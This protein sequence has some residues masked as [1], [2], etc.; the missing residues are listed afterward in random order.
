MITCS[1]GRVTD[2]HIRKSLSELTSV[3]LV[4]PMDGYSDSP[5]FT[6]TVDGMTYEFITMASD[7]LMPSVDDV[8]VHITGVLASQAEWT[9]VKPMSVESAE[10]S[11][12]LKSFGI[13]NGPKNNITFFNL[14]HT[15]GQLSVALANMSPKTAFVDFEKKSVVYYDDMLRESPA[16]VPSTFRK[17]YTR[18]PSVGFMGWDST[19]TIYGNPAMAS[20]LGQ[21]TNVDQT[22]MQ[23]LVDNCNTLSELMSD[24]QMFTTMS[25]L[26]LGA[27]VVSNMDTTKR[28]IVAADEHYSGNDNFI[29]AYYCV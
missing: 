20:K 9:K 13:D 29:A 4:V 7:I 18:T 21:F 14:T 17:K 1:L 23:N 10:I 16:T 22:L 3:E 25:P 5:K 6:V 15:V 11:N 27:T 24:I 19:N 28:L 26:G 2:V 12:V 8:V